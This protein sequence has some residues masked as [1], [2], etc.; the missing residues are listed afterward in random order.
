MYVFSVR[1]VLSTEKEGYSY[2]L[3]K[4]STCTRILHHEFD[5]VQNSIKTA[6]EHMIMVRKNISNNLQIKPSSQPLELVRF[7]HIHLQ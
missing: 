5:G 3:E 4:P 6:F 2:S 1:V 7:H